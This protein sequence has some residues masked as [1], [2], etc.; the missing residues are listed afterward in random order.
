MADE[1][2]AAA[3]RN[4]L[5]D[6]DC[7]VVAGVAGLCH[8]WASEAPVVIS[9]I[10]GAAGLQPTLA[11][12]QAGKRVGIAN[13]E[14][15]VMAGSYMME[16]AAYRATILPIDSEHCAIFQ[17]LAGHSTSE[18]TELQITGSG[19]PLRTAHDLSS[20][21][22]EEALNH[23]TWSMGPKITIDSATLMNKA[24]EIIT[25]AR[26]LFNIEAER[27]A[28]LFIHKVL[29]TLWFLFRMAL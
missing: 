3:C 19:G 1:S 15:L 29:C 23:P 21:T 22:H 9:A 17:C 5:A 25:E 27:I 13:K 26:W 12:I 6:Y 18:V 10:V 4:L 16:Q 7:E 28:L 2:Q 11:A 8:R 20:V 14:P 24:L